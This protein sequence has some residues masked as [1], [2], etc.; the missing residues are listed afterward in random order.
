MNVRS[1]KYEG[2]IH[3]FIYAIDIYQ[4]PSSM[5]DLIKGTGRWRKTKS[6]VHGP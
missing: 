2:S 6:M 5:P 4:A 1:I 3:P